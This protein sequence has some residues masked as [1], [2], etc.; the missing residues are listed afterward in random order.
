MIIL[1]YKNN[2]LNFII[3]TKTAK[4]FIKLFNEITCTKC[5]YEMFAISFTTMVSVNCLDKFKVIAK[6]FI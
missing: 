5:L 1:K 2:N 3:I 6:P 4:V